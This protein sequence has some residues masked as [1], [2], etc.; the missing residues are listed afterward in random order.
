MKAAQHFVGMIFSARIKVEGTSSSPS[1]SGPRRQR[2]FPSA[3]TVGRGT[4][5]QEKKKAKVAKIKAHGINVFV[6]RQPV[7][8][9]AESLFAA[10]GIMCIEHADFEGVGRLSLVTGGEIAS[11]S[12]KPGAVKLGHC[13]RIGEIMIGDVRVG[14]S[15]ACRLAWAQAFPTADQF[16]GRGSVRALH[17]RPLGRHHPNGRQG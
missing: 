12:D 17:R 8:N 3:D 4:R 1:S 7:Y 6:N 11:T 15:V 14:R 16:L 2:A 13:D 5:L 9:Y 10:E